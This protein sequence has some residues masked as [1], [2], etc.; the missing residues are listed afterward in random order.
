MGRGS[1]TQLHVRDNLKHIYLFRIT[2]SFY[3]PQLVSCVWIMWNKWMI[4]GSVINKHVSE[5][6]LEQ[7]GKLIYLENLPVL[8]IKVWIAEHSLIFVALSFE[9]IWI[10]ISNIFSYFE[11]NLT[12]KVFVTGVKRNDMYMYTQYGWIAKITSP[13]TPYRIQN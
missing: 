11:I 7:H 5:G 2:N 12:V 6:S 3:A 10:I 4:H 9:F 8:A 13:Y 1:E